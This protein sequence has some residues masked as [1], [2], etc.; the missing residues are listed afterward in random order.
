[1]LVG[2]DIGGRSAAFRQRPKTRCLYDNLTYADRRP[3]TADRRPPTADRRPHVYGHS[4][5]PENRLPRMPMFYRPAGLPACVPACLRACVPACLR[6]CV[7]ACLRACVPAGIEHCAVQHRGEGGP[8]AGRVGQGSPH[9]QFFFI[10]PSPQAKPLQPP[11]R[12]NRQSG[13]R[14]CSRGI[15]G[16]CSAHCH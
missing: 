2:T 4:R 8:S 7:P 9:E 13:H 11:H 1:M 3:P 6:A 10:W 12:S 5:Q 15:T 14:V 16:P